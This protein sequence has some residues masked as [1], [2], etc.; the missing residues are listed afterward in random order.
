MAK[1]ISNNRFALC[2]IILI[3]LGLFLHY[4]MGFGKGLNLFS[5]GGNKRNKGWGP[6]HKWHHHLFNRNTHYNTTHY[7]QTRDPNI[8]EKHNALQAKYDTLKTHHEVEGLHSH[9]EKCSNCTSDDDPNKHTGGSVHS[10]T[11]Y[12]V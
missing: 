10:A 8:Y 2:I 5:V 3:V 1:S 12:S 11:V 7:K 6:N 4:E 9:Q